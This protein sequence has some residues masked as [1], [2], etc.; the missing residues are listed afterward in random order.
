M[1]TSS[2]ES[3]P[4]EQLE[5]PTQLSCL[6]RYID[7]KPE[8][9]GHGDKDIRLAAL[10]A[11]KYVFD[12]GEISI[13]FYVLYGTLNTLWL[14]LKSEAK[15]RS[16][17]NELLSSLSPSSAP[18]TRS[19][20]AASKNGENGTQVDAPTIMTLEETPIPELC[21]Q[22]M[23]EEQLWA[24]LE[25][26]AKHVCEVL[27]S[28]L[29]STGEVDESASESALNSLADEEMDVDDLAELEELLMAGVEDQDEEGDEEGGG[30]EEDGDDEEEDLGED[31]AELRDPSDDEDE[32]GDL[33]LDQ[34]STGGKRPTRWRPGSRRNSELDDGF[35]DLA[36]FN[37]ETE[38]AESQK[39]SKGR[40]AGDDEDSDEDM[41]DDVDYFATVD[42][43][44]D[45]E[46][47]GTQG[48]Q[49]RFGISNGYSTRHAEIFYKDFFEPP[50]R[51]PAKKSKKAKTP[52]QVADSPK[53]RKSKVRF[54]EEVRVKRI[55]AQGKNLPLSTM[56]TEDEEDEDDDEDYDDEMAEADA[57]ASSDASSENDGEDS[58]E[59]EDSEGEFQGSGSS[60]DE[61]DMDDV[62]VDGEL[63]PQ[64][65]IERLKDDLFADDDEEPDQG[66]KSFYSSLLAY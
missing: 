9:F 48:A 66:T 22:G 16:H 31:I 20:A 17:I 25:L 43:G 47:D 34:P 29:E 28:A 57:S 21:V 50:A 32:D 37:A 30:D 36:A 46:L 24:Q 35:F 45:G 15:S 5:L 1:S 3:S 23:D 61:D 60:E 11:A 55:R 42:E 52:G 58:D 7:T 59:G 18:Q 12:M 38:E 10:Q 53:H 64:D 40:L 51:V 4:D 62:E 63:E 56:L 33:D 19:Q 65:T 14:A 44:V 2:R 27:E 8:S 41:E 13:N 54:H 26:R 6:S 49:V 39:V